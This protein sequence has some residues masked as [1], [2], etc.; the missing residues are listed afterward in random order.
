ML[1]ALALDARGMFL[2]L[3]YRAIYFRPVARRTARFYRLVP[4]HAARDQRTTT[5]PVRR[6]LSYPDSQQ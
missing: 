6:Q 4:D 2:F 5:R 3:H 1:E